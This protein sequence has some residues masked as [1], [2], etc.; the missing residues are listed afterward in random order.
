M[1]SNK[2][3]FIFVHIPK[4]AGVTISSILDDYCTLDEKKKHNMNP[5]GQR[6]Q[7]SRYFKF[8][9]VRNPWDRFLSCYFY[10]RKYGRKI[11]NDTH[12]GEIVNRFDS[13]YEFTINFT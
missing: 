7:I 10:F 4:T 2:H 6:N 3:K 13:F 12:S 9:F 11:A 8:C 5:H 1:V